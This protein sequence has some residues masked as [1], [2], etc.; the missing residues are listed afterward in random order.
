M[1]TQYHHVPLPL[2]GVC[3]PL[4]ICSRRHQGLIFFKLVHAPERVDAYG[5]EEKK[6]TQDEQ[7]RHDTQRPE[8]VAPA[9]HNPGDA[10][11]LVQLFKV[12]KDV[13]GLW[14]RRLGRGCGR[15]CGERPG[16]QR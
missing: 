1:V 10:C 15:H 14:N 9:S 2:C 8:D 7:A 4:R 5:H 6:E 13:H 16:G 3:I 12:A 11:C